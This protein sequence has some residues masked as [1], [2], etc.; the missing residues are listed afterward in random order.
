MIL[1]R[2]ELI[3]AL[4][5]PRW[6]SL[7]R[8][9]RRSLYRAVSGQLVCNGNTESFRRL[10][11]KDSIIWW[12][13]QSFTRKHRVNQA[14]TA[15]PDLPPVIVFKRPQDLSRWLSNVRNVNPA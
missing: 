12:H 14:M 1:P 5:Y 10:L 8:L 7:S 6:V 13:F 3:V 11:T 15:D 9:L 4:D 2:A